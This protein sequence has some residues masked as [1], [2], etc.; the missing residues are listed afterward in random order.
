MMGVRQLIV[1]EHPDTDSF[2][3]HVCV[4]RLIL[5]C[6][7]YLLDSNPMSVIRSYMIRK[8]NGKIMALYNDYSQSIQYFKTDFSSIDR[9]EVTFVDNKGILMKTGAIILLDLYQM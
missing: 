6:P 4:N 9:L 3:G 5:N 2:L 7:T 1:R 8:Q